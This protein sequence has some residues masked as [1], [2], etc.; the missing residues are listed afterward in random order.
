MKDEC[1]HDKTVLT[2]S[3]D[4]KRKHHVTDYSEIMKNSYNTNR[5]S[6]EDLKFEDEPNSRSEDV[7]KDLACPRLSELINIVL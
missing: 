1:C 4:V 2:L 7:P 6:G 5:H 3:H